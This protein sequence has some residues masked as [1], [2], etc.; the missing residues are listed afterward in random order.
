ME[1][2]QDLLA[3]FAVALTPVNLLYV[4]V[5]VAFGTIVGALPG[6]GPATAIAMLLP[7]TFGLEP[8]TAIILL[9]GIYY[10]SMYGGR[11]PAILLNMPGDAPSVVTTFDGYPMAK[12]GRA[13]KALTIAAV[14]SF[15]GGTVGTLALTF[16]APPLAL[17]ALRFG[18]PEIAM[19]TVLG[20]LLIAHL[21]GGS[22][23]K[24]LVTAGAGFLLA[25]VGQ[26]PMLGTERLTLGSGQ[27]LGGI[28]FIP[29][30][31][32]V[33]G[34]GEVLYNLEHRRGSGDTRPVLSGTWPSLQ[35]WVA[36]RFAMLRGAF[37][38]LVIGMAPGAGA[39]IASMTSYA[40][41]K[42]RSKTPERFGKGAAEGV[43]GPEAANNAGAVAAFI[44]LLTLGI[45]GSVTT[46]LIFGALLLQG[47]TPGPTLIADNPSV[48]Y[49]LIASMYIGNVLLLLLNIPLIGVF[50]S[51]LR[52]RFS[53]LSGIVVVILIVGAFSV[54]NAIFDIWIMLA[55][56]VFGY[57]AKKT[58]FNL[59]PFALAYVLS[60]IMERAFRQ[61]L[62]LSEGS[63]A[64]FVTRP[65]SAS[66]VAVGVLVFG[67][68]L[69]R[70]LWRRRRSLAS[71][72]ET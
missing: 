53:I 9:A 25:S 63:L 45:P 54:N 67:V 49:G 41:E 35:E 70:N 3:G 18:P 40:T 71:Q 21:G 2:L 59:G 19:L 5:G 24:G 22:L 32:G 68:P 14:A 65:V 47:I 37:V 48:F 7:L 1:A 43:A 42:R 16:V 11:I 29:V 72:Q 61:S 27:L 33:F 6:F 66:I 56:G 39:E 26:D 23:V 34:L 69:A 62:L 28:S 44:P 64:I 15:I 38:G 46:A 57:L 13:G 58:G 36:V 8:E 52:V 50:V 30:V 60:P 55:F 12:Q 20:V 4:A 31:M 17:F 10:G 51:I